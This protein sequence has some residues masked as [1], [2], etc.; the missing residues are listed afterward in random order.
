MAARGGM[1]PE[2]VARRRA[3]GVAGE[4]LAAGWYTG[5][6]G[7]VLARNWRCREGELDLV[8]R[9]G[10]TIVF[11]EV[12]ARSSAAFGSPLEAVTAPK[13]RRIRVLAA[14]WLEEAQVRPGPLRFDVVG[15]LDGELEVV[16]GAF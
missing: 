5:R 10:R 2:R 16:R 8:V 1:D 6:G 3:L 15:V 4:D 11:V 12:K 9:E 14:R 13:R 7:E